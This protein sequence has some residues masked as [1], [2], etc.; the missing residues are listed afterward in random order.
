VA[1]V[2]K[3]EPRDNTTPTTW[4][5][6]LLSSYAGLQLLNSIVAFNLLQQ[7]YGA[8]LAAALGTLE[9]CSNRLSLCALQCEPAHRT[10]TPAFLSQYLPLLLHQSA[11]HSCVPNCTHH[12]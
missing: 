8:L 4:L 12:S 11:T 2:L 5:N 3:N 7:G 6:L 10:G 9:E 1:R